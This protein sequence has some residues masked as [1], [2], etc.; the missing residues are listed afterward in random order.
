MPIRALVIFLSAAL[1]FVMTMEGIPNTQAGA[2]ARVVTT[3]TST[4]RKALFKF[5]TSHKRPKPRDLIKIQIINVDLLPG[6]QLALA[7]IG[8]NTVQ[9]GDPTTGDVLTL[10]SKNKAT[11]QLGAFPNVFNKCKAKYNPKRRR[12]TF[13]CKKGTAVQIPIDF[14][15]AAGSFRFLSTMTIRVFVNGSSCDYP[16]SFEIRLKNR[17]TGPLL[18]RGKLLR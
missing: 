2:A 10:D 15:T 3:S 1:A 17:P 18:E 12:L 11:G 16:G 9:I 6:D 13:F 4:M 5:I 7:V 14:A 8:D